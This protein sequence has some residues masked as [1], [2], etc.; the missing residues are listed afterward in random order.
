MSTP[1][2]TPAAPA[3]RSG[4][5]RHL[6]TIVGVTVLVVVVVL[7]VLTVLQ[8]REQFVAALSQ[9]GWGTAT[10][11]GLFALGAVCATY[12][13]WTELLAGLGV[14]MPA[15][16]SAPVFFVSQLGKYLPGSVWP[17]LAQMEA[18]RQ[19]GT[20]RRTMLAANL[21][22]LLV[23]LAVGVT[24]AAGLLPLGGEEALDRYWWLFLL[25]PVLLA[26]LHPKVLPW[27]VER[28]FRLLRQPRPDHPLQV[29]RAL[30]AAG[31]ALLSWV[32]FGAHLAVLCAGLGLRGPSV[33]ALATGAMALAVV[34]GILFIPAPA[35][36]GP[37]EVILVLVLAPILLEQQ[38]VAVALVSRVELVAVDLLL[39]GVG[40]LLGV[41][42][43]RR[44]RVE[45]G[46]PSPG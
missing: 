3:G 29:S 39:A 24:V 28:A 15:R 45:A 14:R 19:V 31:W 6:C 7:A 9:I 21:L 20:T 38:A 43:R 41:L 36:A 17:V 2:P 16:L 33:L 37:R 4:P 5:R 44:S 11:S 1:E 10:V 35:G 30:R 18:G 40:A 12:L 32:L 25:L 13:V 27:G 42:G 22:T 8:D 26:M 23:S 46:A 34:V